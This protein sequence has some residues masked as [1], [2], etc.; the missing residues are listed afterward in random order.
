MITVLNIYITVKLK[1]N[2]YLHVVGYHHVLLV[3]VISN[4]VWIDNVYTLLVC[5]F[6]HGLAPIST[7]YLQP[8]YDQL[9]IELYQG[10]V[11]QKDARLRGFDLVTN[12]EL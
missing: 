5:S 7:D 12:I 2:L 8:S 11:T 9:R 6:R 1:N 3:I 4:T 10:S